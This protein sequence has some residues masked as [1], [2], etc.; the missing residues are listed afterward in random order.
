MAPLVSCILVTKDRPAFFRQALGC[1]TDQ[2]Y[3]HKELVVVDDGETSVESLCAGVP[4][5]RYIRLAALTP[6]GTK[7]NLGIDAARGDILQKLDDDDFYAPEFLSSA[8][9]RLRRARRRDALVV[10]CCFVVLIARERGLYF[11]GHG[12]KTGGTLCF[13]RELWRGRPFRDMFHSSDSWFIRDNKPFI[14]RVCDAA[15]QYMIVRHGANTWKRIGG[16]DSVESYFR[17]HPY[18]HRTVRQI[19]GRRHAAFYRALTSPVPTHA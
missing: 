4:N 15:E 16:E 18:R 8:V 17:K 2:D 12:W 14:A 13:R 10:W 19:V 7:L 5:V 1:F 3:P 9:T 6:T 11:S